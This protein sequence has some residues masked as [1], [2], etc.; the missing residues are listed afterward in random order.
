MSK[1]CERNHT[2]EYSQVHRRIYFCE[3]M[4]YIA[5]VY[6]YWIVP[7]IRTEG[8]FDID[9]VGIC[10]EIIVDNLASSIDYRKNPIFYIDPCLGSAYICHIIRDK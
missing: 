6:P 5:I 1:S 10:R 7:I 9:D 3:N 8:I 2:G 4:Q